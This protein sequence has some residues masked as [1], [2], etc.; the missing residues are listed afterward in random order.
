MRSRRRCS[1]CRAIGG[2]RESGRAYGRFGAVAGAAA[3]SLG[4]LDSGG[5]C[6]SEG[7]LF[8]ARVAELPPHLDTARGAAAQVARALEDFAEVLADAQRRMAGALDQATQTHRSLGGARADRAGLQERPAARPPSW[9]PAS[10][11][12]RTPGTASWPPPPGPAP[13]SWR[14]PA[15]ARPRS[16]PPGGSPPTADQS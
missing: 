13:R 5:G 16:G 8:R 1:P 15:A 4:G 11:G 7:D 12:W 10:A 14:L 2:V 9:T 6:G 3:A